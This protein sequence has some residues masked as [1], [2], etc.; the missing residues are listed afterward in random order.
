MKNKGKD[1]QSYP[2]KS[3]WSNSN[4]KV[5]LK[6]TVYVIMIKKKSI[7]KNDKIQ[8]LHILF[9]L[10]ENFYDIDITRMRYRS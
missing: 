3:S 9:F 4:V 7:H 1:G 6:R 10:K 5:D 8:T 2:N